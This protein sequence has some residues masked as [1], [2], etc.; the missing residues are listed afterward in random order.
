M[1]GDVENDDVERV[2]DRRRLQE[3]GVLLPLH[4]NSLSFFSGRHPLG[5]AGDGMRFLRSRPF[6]PGQ[7]N[8][9]NIDKFSPPGEYLVNDWEA[10]A[11]ASICIYG[12][13]SASMQFGPQ[14]ALLNRT[15]LQLTYSL[16]RASDRVRT[17]LY[18]ADSMRAISERNLRGQLDA[19]LDALAERHRRPG[20]D[21]AAL[22]AEQARARHG[23]SDDLAFVVSD[24]RTPGEGNYDVAAWQTA[25]RLTGCDVVPVI[26]SFE[27]ATEQRGSMQLWDPIAGQRRLLCMTP[28]RVS[29]INARERERTE[30]LAKSF[31]QQGVA[32]IVLRSPRSVFAELSRLARWRRRS[33]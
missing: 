29:D 20:R 21:A 7:D 13:V 26:V 9:R 31:R 4:L 24:F 16:W 33:G 3:A 2:L 1:R 28:P 11:Q 25:M 14:R 32:C 12:D 19:L 22:L 6:E 27:L 15:L 30:G 23:A 17:L 10:E 8:P 18:D 5:R